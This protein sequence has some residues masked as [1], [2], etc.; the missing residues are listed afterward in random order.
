MAETREQTT[1]GADE[2]KRLVDAAFSEHASEG[3]P[4]IDVFEGCEAIVLGT[5]L[6]ALWG[7]GVPLADVLEFVAMHHKMT[8][9]AMASAKEGA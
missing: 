4:T 7:R 8:T 2:V 9:R 6:G 1:Q 5:V 3:R